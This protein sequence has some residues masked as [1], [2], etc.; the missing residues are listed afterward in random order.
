MKMEIRIAMRKAMFV[1]GLIILILGLSLIVSE[2]TETILADAGQSSVWEDVYEPVIEESGSV[3]EEEIGIGAVMGLL[4]LI[5]VVKGMRGGKSKNYESGLLY[6]K[7]KHVKTDHLA[8]RIEVA[9]KEGAPLES[10][11]KKDVDASSLDLPMDDDVS[12]PAFTPPTPAQTPTFQP[13]AAPAPGSAAT[14]PIADGSVTSSTVSTPDST[15]GNGINLMIDS[16]A[17]EGVSRSAP[18]SSSGDAS[19][20]QASDAEKARNFKC[21]SCNA[22]F[23]LKTD[24]DVIICPSCGTKYNLPK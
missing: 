21:S 9:E 23:S 13:Q 7:L 24:K 12:K 19:P 4:G 10:P 18:A 11:Y 15:F 14:A 22:S 2:R 17:L 5:L 8:D 20:P 1:F 3:P 6:Q 16:S